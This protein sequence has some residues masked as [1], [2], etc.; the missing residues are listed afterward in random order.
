MVV[1][2]KIMINDLWWM[3]IVIEYYLYRWDKFE[4][5]VWKDNIM[6]N[7]GKK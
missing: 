4:E 6:L 3:N 1:W 2:K 7:V 5:W